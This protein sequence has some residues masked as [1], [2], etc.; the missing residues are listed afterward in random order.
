MCQNVFTKGMHT[1][2]KKSTGRAYNGKK[3]KKTPQK[4]VSKNQ[5][6]S[7]CIMRKTV[8]I[9]WKT[10]SKPKG[11]GMTKTLVFQREPYQKDFLNTC[12]G[13]LWWDPPSTVLR[14]IYLV[15]ILYGWELLG[16]QLTATLLKYKPCAPPPSTV[17]TC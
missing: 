15:V 2:Q 9:T 3:K 5:N 8:N 7:A 17:T 13:V 10:S 16:Y 12:W 14:V 6:S 1:W 11:R 4:G